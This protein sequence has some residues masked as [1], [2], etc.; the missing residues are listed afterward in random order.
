[1]LLS[2]IFVLSLYIIIPIQVQ[3]YARTLENNSS[4]PPLSMDFN[5]FTNDAIYFNVTHTFSYIP[6]MPVVLYFNEPIRFQT[7]DILVAELDID[8]GHLLFQPNEQLTL[9]HNF[10]MT[11]KNTTKFS[12]LWKRWFRRMM[13]VDAPSQLSDEWNELQIKSTWHI[14]SKITIEFLGLYFSNI[15]VYFDYQ[16]SGEFSGDSTFELGSLGLQWNISESISLFRSNGYNLFEALKPL[17]KP[18]VPIRYQ[19]TG[20]KSVYFGDF[21]CS[22][23]S[24]YYP[25]NDRSHKVIHKIGEAQIH[26]LKYLPGVHTESLHFVI[27]LEEQLQSFIQMGQN[28]INNQTTHLQIR[29]FKIQIPW[30]TEPVQWV[31][32]SLSVLYFNVP[33]ARS[34]PGLNI[35]FGMIR[36]GSVLDYVSASL[37][38]QPNKFTF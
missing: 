12:N 36:N 11:L 7:D 17:V 6:L 35:L 1:M 13:Y 9:E 19:N 26:N 25:G 29:D 34:A 33:I 23:S 14:S 18:S 5:M 10:T 38:T 28:F 16:W 21:H 37:E 24:V 20:V 15:P 4:D 30:Q 32:D 22:F 3:K 27:Y 31:I 2:F 8:F